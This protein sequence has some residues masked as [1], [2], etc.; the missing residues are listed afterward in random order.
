MAADAVLLGI[1]FDSKW[2]LERMEYRTDTHKYNDLP[3]SFLVPDINSFKG[4]VSS[5]VNIP[6]PHKFIYSAGG[7]TGE[8]HRIDEN[9]GGFGDKVHEILFVD[10]EDLEKADKTRA[11]LVSLPR[12]SLS[13]LSRFSSEIEIWFA[14]DRVYSRSAIRFHTR[15]WNQY[16]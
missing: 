15:A 6:P 14:R 13:D 10:E 8:V 11:A 7:P 1:D 16:D 2:R 5:Y 12:F 9:T 4:A 3:Q